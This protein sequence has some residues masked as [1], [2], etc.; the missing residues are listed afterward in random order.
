MGAQELQAA[1]D[2]ELTPEQEAA[3]EK[4]VYD[5]EFLMH[6]ANYY[7]EKMH[8]EVGACACSVT[9]W[10]HCSSFGL[11]MWFLD[12]GEVPRMRACLPLRPSNGPEV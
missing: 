12:A 8:V 7:R 5:A 4:E 3:E 11:G 6:K 1:A 10:G 2:E 9:L